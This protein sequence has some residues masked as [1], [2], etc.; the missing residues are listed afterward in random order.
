[1]KHRILMILILITPAFIFAAPPKEEV[2]LSDEE[3]AVLDLT[4]AERKKEKLEPLTMDPK[5]LE[6]A[7]KHAANMAKQDKLEH[8]LDDKAAND[9]VKAEGYVYGW[10]GENIA[11]NALTP[12]EVVQGW[13]D[14]KPHRENIL[15]KEYTQLGMAVVK[16][17]KGEPYWVQVFGTPRAK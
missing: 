6:A 12:K 8:K 10:L 17:S 4:N 2:K 7:R 14:S 11:W 13:M 16:N 1:M 15:K 5:L 3:Q 9:R